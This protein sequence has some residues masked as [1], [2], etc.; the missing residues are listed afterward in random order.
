MFH[1]SRTTLKELKK[2][3]L[4]ILKKC[5]LA[6]LMMFA[7]S[8]TAYSGTA[9][10]TSSLIAELEKNERTIVET[11]THILTYDKTS[12]LYDAETNSIIFPSVD[13]SQSGLLSGGRL[14]NKGDITFNSD[15]KLVFTENKHLMTS[16]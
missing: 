6:N 1:S 4:N 2:R 7:F 8:L 10:D 14:Y 11:G 3:Y 5:L 15:L 16:I 9:T 13:I 12:S